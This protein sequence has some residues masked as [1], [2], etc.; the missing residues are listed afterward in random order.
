MEFSLTALGDILLSLSEMDLIR[1][2]RMTMIMS[3]AMIMSTVSTISTISIIA[4][5]SVSNGISTSETT[6]VWRCSKDYKRNELKSLNCCLLE[7]RW[8]KCSHCALGAAVA[9]FI[10]SSITRKT[11]TKYMYYFK[12]NMNKTN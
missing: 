8:K 5:A 4:V 1:K 3:V 6:I 11:A 2:I 7:N 9:S 12:K 10:R